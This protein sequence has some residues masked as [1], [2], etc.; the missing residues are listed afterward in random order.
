M[1]TNTQPRILHRQDFQSFL[2][3]ESSPCI[4]MFIPTHR[5]GREQRQDKIRL[6]NLLARVEKEL[7]FGDV[8]RG[9]I[10]PLTEFDNAKGG[11]CLALSA[12]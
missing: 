9:E 12:A 2:N 8:S 6:K 11:S 1:K 4:T 7:L 5:T 3:H 10:E